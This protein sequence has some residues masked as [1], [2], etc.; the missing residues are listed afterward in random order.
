MPVPFPRLL[1]PATAALL[2]FP[3]IAAAQARGA[4]T[5]DTVP[6]AML[7]PAGKCR[8][9]MEGVPAAQ[10][11]APTDCA[12]A[13]RTKPA[14]GVVLYGPMP[15]GDASER[16][17]PRVGADPRGASKAEAMRREADREEQ[18]AREREERRRRMEELRTRDEQ[19][20]RAA[21]DD[22][23]RVAPEVPRTTGTAGTTTPASTG[24][25]AGA[26]PANSRAPGGEAGT[27][28]PAEPK[29]KPE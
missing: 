21:V 4:S 3:A 19:V 23:R 2:A 5:R 10:Q 24:A 17:D 20:R 8:I 15:R 13:L 14:N 12:T 7:P 11:P 22:R 1:R 6:P 16:F 28:P 29:K 18:L 27:K 9:W 26:T 25:P